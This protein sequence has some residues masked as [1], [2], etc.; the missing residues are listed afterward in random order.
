MNTTYNKIIESK[1]I[2]FLH[3]IA[4]SK[5]LSNKDSISTTSK[6]LNFTRKTIYSEIKRGTMEKI[7]SDLTTKTVYDVYK[8]EGLYRN[9]LSKRGRLT[10]S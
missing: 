1:N 7:N 9:S 10:K 4:I 8:A 6:E 3:R 5:A 2:K